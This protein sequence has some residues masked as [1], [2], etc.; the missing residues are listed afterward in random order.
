MFVSVLSFYYVVTVLVPAYISLQTDGSSHHRNGPNFFGGTF[1]TGIFLVGSVL[2]GSVFAWTI[3]AGSARFLVPLLAGNFLESWFGVI[4]VPNGVKVLG[5]FLVYG[6]GIFGALF[7]GT[8]FPG[9]ILMA[10]VGA[11]GM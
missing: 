10:T 1:F 9:C 4:F 11:L 8:A 2:A 5:I 6:V 3:F 7:A